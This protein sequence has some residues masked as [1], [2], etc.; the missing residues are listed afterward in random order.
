MAAPAPVE[1]AVAAPE[2]EWAPPPADAA[3]GTAEP[4]PVEPLFQEPAY[5]E[6]AYQEPAYQ[7]PAPPEIPYGELTIQ[8]PA[9]QFAPD[10]AAWAPAPIHPQETA[11]PGATAPPSTQTEDGFGPGLTIAPPDALLPGA[12]A[13]PPNFGEGPI[14]PAGPPSLEWPPG[15]LAVAAAG[16][17]T[18]SGTN[19]DL[20]AMASLAAPVPAEA[21]A[22]AAEMTADE[23]MGWE[24]PPEIGPDGRGPWMDGPDAP[25]GSAPS[26]PIRRAVV[27]GAWGIGIGLVAA[28]VRLFLLN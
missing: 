26:Q 4:A 8:E 28:I 12:F 20:A 25:W 13:L 16:E 5:K 15:D 17:G 23:D 18:A 6:P 3:Q 27:A 21:A 9:A 14:L 11:G 1:A 19:A 7:E 2:P 22:Y 24:G 10:A